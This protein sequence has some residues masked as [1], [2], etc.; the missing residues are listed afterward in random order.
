[1]KISETIIKLKEIQTRFGDISII[2]G[3]MADDTVLR[4]ICVVDVNGMEVFP[5]D[6]NGVAGNNDIEGVF[7]T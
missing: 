2:G 4:N 6:P 3:Y 1:M 5:S 7:L